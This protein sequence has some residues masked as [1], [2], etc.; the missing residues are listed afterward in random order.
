MHKTAEL[1]DLAEIDLE[2]GADAI[3]LLGLALF[4]ASVFDLL[5]D[6]GLLITL[7]AIGEYLLFFCAMMASA[8]VVMS[9][10]QLDYATFGEI[11]KSD[12]GGASVV[13]TPMIIVAVAVSCVRFQ[14]LEV[15]RLKVGGQE[16]MSMPM[17][18]K[19]Y[20]FIQQVRR[21][22]PRDDWFLRACSERACDALACLR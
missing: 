16:L 22:R 18:Q 7:L 8:G 14:S 10:L 13:R 15:L 20:W 6:V 9:T 3:G 2:P 21:K 1:Y 4:V 19:H 17:E 5:S 12:L 11:A